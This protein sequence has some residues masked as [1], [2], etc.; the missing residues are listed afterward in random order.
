MNRRSPAAASQAPA[1]EPT[2]LCSGPAGSV[3]QCSCGNLH[4][5][6][7]YITLRFEPDAF[8]ELVGLLAIAQHRLDR[9]H[10]QPALQPRVDADITPIH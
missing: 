2:L 1:H 3:A 8:R 10:S 9:D 6:L 7:Q 5:N 4:V